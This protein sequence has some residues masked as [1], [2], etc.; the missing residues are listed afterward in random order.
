MAAGAPIMAAANAATSGAVA[1]AQQFATALDGLYNS[2]ANGKTPLGTLQ[3]Q[4]VAL[5][6]KAGEQG[7][8]GEL[9]ALISGTESTSQALENLAAMAGGANPEIA[10][11]VANYRAAGGAAAASESD[12]AKFALD[13]LNIRKNAEDAAT[14]VAAATA[15]QT[16]T[17]G[18]TGA[19]PIDAQITSFDALKP[20]I[21]AASES[22]KNYQIVVQALD[23]SKIAEQTSAIDTDR[24]AVDKLSEG[25]HNLADFLDDHEFHVQ[26]KVDDIPDWATPGSPTP[27]EMGL[28]GIKRAADRLKPISLMSSDQPLLTPASRSA[29]FSGG[30]GGGINVAEITIN[31]TTDPAATARAVRNELVKL[32]RRNGGGGKVLS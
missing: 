5:A 23:P 26:V 27:F 32:G 8:A 30:G 17:G 2:V 19:S 10:A 21:D 12:T 9:D 22:L 16:A 1:P 7:A 24:E 13:L 15:A 31:G 3:L 11:L 14:A 25:L 29:A 28:R 4:L 18:K 6:A 20:K